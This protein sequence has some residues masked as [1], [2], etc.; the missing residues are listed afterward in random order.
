MSV[1]KCYLIVG[2]IAILCF[3]LFHLGGIIS[4]GMSY[5]GNTEVLTK[6]N[7]INAME[8]EFY[9]KFSLDIVS[10]ENNTLAR[11]HF[12]VSFSLPSLEDNLEVLLTIDTQPVVYDFLVYNDFLYDYMSLD[13]AQISVGAGDET[14]EYISMSGLPKQVIF[15]EGLTLVKNEIILPQNWFNSENKTV[16]FE[17]GNFQVVKRERRFDAKNFIGQTNLIMKFNRTHFH[18]G[19]VSEDYGIFDYLLTDFSV[20]FTSKSVVR[21]VLAILICFI[22]VLADYIFVSDI[23]NCCTRRLKARKDNNL[24]NEIKVENSTENGTELQPEISTDE[25]TQLESTIIENE[26]KLKFEKLARRK[27]FLFSVSTLLFIYSVLLY[28]FGYV[29]FGGPSVKDY[30]FFCIIAALL[31]Y[32]VYLGTIG[33]MKRF[34]HMVFEDN[35]DKEEVLEYLNDT[36]NQYKSAT[37]EIIST[38]STLIALYLFIFG[39]S[40]FQSLWF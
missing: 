32:L 37:K 25:E 34:R 20:Y 18:E 15:S 2:S 17:F 7:N 33:R 23:V 31:S 8:F 35:D 12:M 5:K 14:L 36:E 4:G 40:A 19:S 27:G 38:I 29:I 3:G 39:G 28:L 11:V 26:N 1:K 30:P 16:L 6:I 13:I 9:Q 21:I 10:D 24:E 22:A